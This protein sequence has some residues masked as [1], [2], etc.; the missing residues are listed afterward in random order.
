[1]R[2]GAVT[3]R[4]RRALW[5]RPDP[6][7][8]AGERAR[9]A[10]AAAPRSR[11][12]TA[13]LERAIAALK[14][15]DLAAFARE[16][17]SWLRG[18]RTSLCPPASIYARR[19]RLRRLR[20][21]CHRAGS[22]SFAPEPEPEVV[23]VE[24]EEAF[25]IAEPSPSS[26]RA[27]RHGGRK[28]VVVDVASAAEPEPEPELAPEPE[29]DPSPS[30]AL[31]QRRH[32]LARRRA[33]DRVRARPGPRQWRQGPRAARL[34]RAMSSKSLEDSVKEMLRPMLSNGSTRTCRA[35]SP[36]RFARSLRIPTCGGT[37]R[38]PIPHPE[39]A[40]ERGRLEG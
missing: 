25:V 9:D 31:A 2:A 4:R 40:A 26:S 30:H 14:A 18:A 17:Q 20:R 23:V 15:G 11:I 35:C 5:K 22:P 6:R 27:R 16:A 37:A 39:E 10:G 29:F 19:S 28:P 21:A 1:M 12:P 34:R 24:E 13:A 8:D 32:V 3:T 38:H 7:R 33:G 36:R